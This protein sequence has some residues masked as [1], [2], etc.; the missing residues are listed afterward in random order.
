MPQLIPVRKGEELNLSRLESHL[1]QT[2][3]NLPESSLMVKQFGAGASNL[4]YELTIGS[5]E[6]V[7]RRAPLGKVAAKAHDMEREFHVLASLYDQFP[8]APKPLYYCPDESIAGKPFLLMERK[9]GVL[10]ESELPN[11]M[12]VT[13]EAGIRLSEQMLDTLV[14]LHHV[15][16]RGSKLEEISKPVG[17]MERQVHG[18]IGRFDRA[19]TD[20]VK[21]FPELKKW[22]ISHIPISQDA[23]VIHYDYKFNNALFSD[24]LSH[25]TGLFD[26]EMATIGDPL[27][28][29]GAAMS[30]WVEENDPDI[31]KMGF[32]KPPI[33]TKS[34]FFTR[35]EFIQRYAQKSG[36]DVSGIHYYLT[37]AYFKLAVICQQIYYRYKK[38]QTNDSR[39][40]KFG[41]FA[42]AL[43]EHSWTT[44][45]L[46]GK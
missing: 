42:E 26:W 7:L 22:L 19:Q 37:F 10:L 45:K 3:P 12:E 20:E 9:Y 5:W 28:D 34:G 29:V 4:T 11:G 31:L 38:G 43:I 27:A 1:R 16:Y 18:W 30:Y 24:D 17:F 46:G 13:E 25:M 44:A 14:K 33:T 36:R 39:F 35:N 2:I 15:D 41:E 6:A 8:L 40:R 21:A 23:T 32:G